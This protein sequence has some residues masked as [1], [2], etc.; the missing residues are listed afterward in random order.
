MPLQIPATSFMM[1]AHLMGVGV[2]VPGDA[3]HL[4]EHEPDQGMA[5]ITAVRPVDT[6]ENCLAFARAEAQ[7]M[8]LTDAREQSGG[9]VTFLQFSEGVSFSCTHIAPANGLIAVNGPAELLRA[10]GYRF[11]N[12]R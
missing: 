6:A 4:S 8:N 10:Q 7:R 9:A 11:T 5:M 2:P 3:W 12:P 1:F